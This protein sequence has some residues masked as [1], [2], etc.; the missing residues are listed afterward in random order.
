MKFKQ[1]ASST[2]GDETRNGWN[3]HS[4]SAPSLGR[5][6][7]RDI[8]AC[9]SYEVNGKQDSIRGE[10]CGRREARQVEFDECILSGHRCNPKH[11]HRRC[12]CATGITE[13]TK[14][15]RKREKSSQKCRL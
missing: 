3:G 10:D 12:N 2:T 15:D 9:Q 14:R 6:L 1:S 4:D 11:S 8:A 13:R 5:F 7:R